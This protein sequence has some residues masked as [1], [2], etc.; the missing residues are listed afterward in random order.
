[1]VRS[2]IQTS[3]VAEEFV[4]KEAGA[5]RRKDLHLHF[6]DV[7]QIYKEIAIEEIGTPFDV[8]V[9]DETQDL[10]DQHKLG[11][12][13]LSLVG[14]L[15][16]GQCT[17]LGDFT[18]QSLYGDKINPVEVISNY[19]EHFV[20][21]KLTINFRNTKGIAEETTIFSGFEEPPFSMGS[22]SRLP[23]EH[24]YWKIPAELLKSFVE[25]VDNLTKEIMPIENIILLSLYR[26]ENSSYAG[27]D[28]IRPHPLVDI[29]RS[30]PLEHFR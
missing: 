1:M 14:E 22:E 26:L 4:A 25:V 24:R 16:G 20:A 17:K 29:S 8:L 27:I 11:F 15:A 6:N 5:L 13:N 9:V 7:Y 3:S 28:R 21:V 18:H 2:I 23:V 30:E 10:G 12:L 19:S